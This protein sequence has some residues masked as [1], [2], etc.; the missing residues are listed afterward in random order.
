MM[1]NEL[2][3]DGDKID[4]V[5]GREGRAGSLPETARVIRVTCFWVYDSPKD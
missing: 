2:E 4:S 5:V 1:G 3:D